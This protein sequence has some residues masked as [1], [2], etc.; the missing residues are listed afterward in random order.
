MDSLY[1]LIPLSL[2]AMVGVIAVFAWAVH[3]GD[4][5]RVLQVEALGDMGVLG[6]G[7]GLLRS[8]GRDGRGQQRPSPEVA[9][10]VVVPQYRTGF[11]GADTELQVERALKLI[12]ANIATP[13]FLER[14]LGDD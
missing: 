11:V 2:L 12:V 13:D 10:G 3:G 7:C 9:H 8:L 14:D 5:D 1:L 4:E 6:R